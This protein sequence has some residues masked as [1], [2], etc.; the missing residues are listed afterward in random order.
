VVVQTGDLT[1]PG[2][3]PALW[4][5]A[6]AVLDDVDAVLRADPTLGLVSKI[7][8]AEL[9]SLP[10]IRSDPARGGEVTVE[11]LITYKTRL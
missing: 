10:S 11:F 9:G 8:V 2:A 4:D 5:S 7:T 6:F 3:V 1:V